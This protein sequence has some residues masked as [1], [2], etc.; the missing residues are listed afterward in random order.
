LIVITALS[1]FLV[2]LAIFLSASYANAFLSMNQVAGDQVQVNHF[3]R[4]GETNKQNHESFHDSIINL[5]SQT[6]NLTKQR[7]EQDGL[8]PGNLSSK[9]V[10]F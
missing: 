7:L 6:S 4:F 2:L 8:L 5:N 9:G 1:K 3:I 10:L